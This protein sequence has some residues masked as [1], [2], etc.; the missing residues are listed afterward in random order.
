MAGKGKETHTLICMA[1][2]S[3]LSEKIFSESLIPKHQ[4][5]N[6]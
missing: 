4:D 6:T 1:A 3:N 2:S 5:M